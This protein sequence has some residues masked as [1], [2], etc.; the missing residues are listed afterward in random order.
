MGGVYTTS[1]YKWS[2]VDVEN[3]KGRGRRKEESDGVLT[4]SPQAIYN[5][6]RRPDYSA[7]GC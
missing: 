1:R 3:K 2:Q 4:V 6:E 5:E 7:T